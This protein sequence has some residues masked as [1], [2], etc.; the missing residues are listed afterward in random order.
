MTAPS[1]DMICGRPS[2]VAERLRRR[3]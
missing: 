3:L 1:A 2:T